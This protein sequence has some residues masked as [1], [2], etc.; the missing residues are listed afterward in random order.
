MCKFNQK[1]L[2]ILCHQKTFFFLC[3]YKM[4]SEGERLTKERKITAEIYMENKAHTRRVYKIYVQIYCKI[5]K[6]NQVTC[7][8]KN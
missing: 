5:C 4:S 3:N 2:S 6:K 7:F 1:L 8:Q